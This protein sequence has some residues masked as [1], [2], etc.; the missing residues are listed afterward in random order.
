[1]FKLRSNR[2]FKTLSII[3]ITLGII[4][5]LLIAI[6]YFFLRYHPILTAHNEDFDKDTNTAIVNVVHRMLRV[7]YGKFNLEILEDI[8]S[9][10]LLQRVQEDSLFQGFR[11]NG[12]GLFMITPNFMQTLTYW[13]TS[14]D[15][16]NQ[17]FH[18]RVETDNDFSFAT[19]GRKIHWLVLIKTPN[20]DVTIVEIDYDR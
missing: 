18:L 6:I 7:H 8:L 10:N 2:V 4:I 16:G 19:R 3:L 1:M 9:E 13:G 17:M 5:I 15:T 12:L 11:N 14:S 20:G